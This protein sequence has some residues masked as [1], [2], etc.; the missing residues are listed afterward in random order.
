[1]SVLTVVVGRCI[2]FLLSLLFLVEF[3]KRYHLN[4][5]RFTEND[6]ITK[7]NEYRP[8]MFRIDFDQ[9]DNET[10]NKTQTNTRERIGKTNK[11]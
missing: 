11:R 10:S 8:Y 7:T 3:S 1:M 5:E 6:S 9:R 2:V 4:K